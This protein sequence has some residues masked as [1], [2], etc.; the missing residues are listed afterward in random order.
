MSEGEGFVTFFSSLIAAALWGVW[1]YRVLRPHRMLS[2]RGSRWPL[3][4]GPLAANILIFVVLLLFSASDV[5]ND[6]KYLAMYTVLGAAWTALFSRLFPLLG[7]HALDDV[8]QRRNAA[9]GLL[10]LGVLVGIALTYAGGNIGDGPGWWVVFFSSGIATVSLVLVWFLLA[11]VTRTTE[12]VVLDRDR[13]AAVR[14][15]ALLT[16]LGLVFGRAAAGNWQGVGPALVDFLNVS[17]P[18]LLLLAPEIL[19]SWMFRPTPR[20]PVP[21]VSLAG[22]GPAAIYLGAAGAYVYTLGWW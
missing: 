19:C 20:Q 12:H 11:T 3:Y 6:P 17:A 4:V 7:L 16:A 21:P 5:R 22:V 8:V 1:V 13:A 18:G 14:T 2:S 10:Y 15:G 9:S